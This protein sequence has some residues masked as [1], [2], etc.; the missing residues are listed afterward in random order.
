MYGGF[1]LE[2]TAE[3]QRNAEGQEEKKLQTKQMER[4]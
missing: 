3:T 4:M 2:F 1:V